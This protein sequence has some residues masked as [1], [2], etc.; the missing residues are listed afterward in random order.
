MLRTAVSNGL[1]HGHWNSRH[2]SQTVQMGV[3]IVHMSGLKEVESCLLTEQP[4][5]SHTAMLCEPKHKANQALVRLRRNPK[6]M[7][8]G[9]R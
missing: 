3:R 8:Q 5:S 9:L 2:D 6:G 1:K 4:R 7:P